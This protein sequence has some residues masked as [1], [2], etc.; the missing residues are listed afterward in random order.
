[1]GFWV[2]VDSDISRIHNEDCEH[3][4][5]VPKTEGSWHYA[6]NWSDILRVL[7]NRFRWAL[8]KDCNPN[9]E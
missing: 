9:T 4:N 5:P 2:N 6:E 7:R 1:M 3:V 8:C